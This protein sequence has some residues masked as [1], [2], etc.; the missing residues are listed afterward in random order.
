MCLA[1]GTLEVRDHP[2]AEG[3]VGRDLLT[4]GDLGRNG[5]QI[6]GRQEA[7]REV[8]LLAEAQGLKYREIA[9]ILEIPVGT[10]KSRMNAAVTR[11]RGMLGHVLK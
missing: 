6:R 3:S 1:N 7:Q 10:V 8:F 2:Q 4:A 11:L 9:A 5:S